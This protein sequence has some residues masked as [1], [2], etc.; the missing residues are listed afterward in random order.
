MCNERC[1][2][3]S[4]LLLASL[5]KPE[6]KLNWREDSLSNAKELLDFEGEHSLPYKRLTSAT[7]KRV[8]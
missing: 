8:T 6:L 5:G 7:P 4:L 2:F 3:H 1:L